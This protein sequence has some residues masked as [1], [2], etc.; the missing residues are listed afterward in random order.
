MVSALYE[1]F[2]NPLKLLTFWFVYP[3]L[4]WSAANVA[5][6]RLHDRGR[7]GWWAALVLVGLAL[8]WPNTHGAWT[9]FGVVVLVWTLVELGLMPGE[10]G[11]NRYG[12]SPRAQPTTA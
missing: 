10:Q 8:V 5:S 2:G 11:A 9:V 6:K 1:A 12:P 3:L 4:W 7:S